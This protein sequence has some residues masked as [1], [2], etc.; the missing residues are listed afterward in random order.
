[1]AGKRIWCL[2]DGEKVIQPDEL[3]TC[4]Q[5]SMQLNYQGFLMDAL[6]PL[7]VTRPIAGLL[8]TYRTVYTDVV[9]G[10]FSRQEA[11]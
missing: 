3:L 8:G 2:P 9:G 11:A 5:T 1:M 6:E 10:W 7:L 4:K